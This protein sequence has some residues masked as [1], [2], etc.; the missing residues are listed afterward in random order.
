MIILRLTKKIIYKYV[1][2][3]TDSKAAHIGYTVEKEDS[4]IKLTK[5]FDLLGEDTLVIICEGETKLY[6]GT[7]GKCT[8]E[9]W[10]HAVV[11]EMEFNNHLERYI[12]T[13]RYM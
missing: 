11:K 2:K 7:C 8:K 10:G 9:V 13:V 4:M 5:L 3:T 12:I 6:S 1:N